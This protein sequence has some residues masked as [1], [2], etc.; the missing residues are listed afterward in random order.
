MI[1]AVVIGSAVIAPFLFPVF[2]TT[3]LAFIA[4]LF[5]PLVPLLV[6]VLVDF[7]YSVPGG[8]LPLGTIG[9]LLLFLLSFFVRGFL[10]TR[11]MW[12]NV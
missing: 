2:L 9:G 3:A 10:K 1:R 11:I 12:G 6:G 7:L 5:V 8:G 4:G